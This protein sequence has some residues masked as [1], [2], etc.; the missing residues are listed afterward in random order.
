MN[1]PADGIIAITFLSIL[2][3]KLIALCTGKETWKHYFYIMSICILK[4]LY[5]YDSRG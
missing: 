1:L 5:F 3:Q 4:F 2:V